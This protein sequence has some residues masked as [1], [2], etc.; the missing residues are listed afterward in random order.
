MITAKTVP[1]DCAALVID[2]ETSERYG[3]LAVRRA[4]EGWH[5]EAARPDG[6]ARPWARSARQED[7]SAQPRSLPAQPRDATPRPE[8]IEPGD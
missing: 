5:I 6:Y 2:R 7:G 8:D 4:G 1:A 3:A